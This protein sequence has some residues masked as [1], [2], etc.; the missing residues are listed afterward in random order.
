MIN[1]S[2]LKSMVG[3]DAVVEKQL[4]KLLCTQLPEEV[5]AMNNAIKKQD[6]PALRVVCHQFKSTLAYVGVQKLT[7]AN[8]SIERCLAANPQAVPAAEIQALFN[9]IEAQIPPI[10][11]ALKREIKTMR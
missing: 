3:H 9:K 6:W 8:E 1:L 4:L 7:A 2:Y 5:G 10:I 11:A